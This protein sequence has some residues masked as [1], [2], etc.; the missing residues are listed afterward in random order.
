MRKAKIITTIILSCV[1]ILVSAQNNSTVVCGQIEKDLNPAKT[2]SLDAFSLLDHYPTNYLSFINPETGTFRFEF[3][4]NTTEAIVFRSSIKLTLILSPGDS[5]FIKFNKDGRIK[6]FGANAQL[7][8][9]ILNY[10]LQ[11]VQEN[12]NPNCEG[13]TLNE[14]KQELISWTKTELANLQRFETK[15]NPSSTFKTWA[16]NEILYRNANYLLDYGIYKQM[17]NLPL[18]D[19]LMD[20][21]IFPANNDE[22]LIAS[23][24]ISHLHEYLASTYKFHELIPKQANDYNNF[25]NLQP[26]LDKLIAN[27]NVSR[28]RDVLV[29]DLFNSLVKL[30]LPN[31]TS[32]INVNINKIHDADLQEQYKKRIENFKTSGR[33][34]TFLGEENSNNKI[35]SNVLQDMTKRFSG[36]VIYVDFWATWCGPC[37]KEFTYSIALEE[38][39]DESK[40]AFVYVCMNSEMEKWQASVKNLKLNHNQYF[41]NETESK[42]FRK[43][44]QIYSFPTYYLI[45]KKGEVVNND[46]PRPSSE[47]LKA[48][49]QTLMNAQ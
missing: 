8:E 27:E 25:K 46:A 41:L 42:A 4:L 2:V 40:V 30:D 31:A 5:L 48:K 10:S 34:I 6:F 16:K 7:N 20:N 23:D 22:A 17:N 18:E 38:L 36:K 39:F 1:H 44:L 26:N 28:S 9:E 11:K 29:I 12:F 3:P 47:L 21:A 13:K 33:P 19:G 49:I 45:D 32:F 14:Y 43:K 24:Y 37:K 15:Y 35:I